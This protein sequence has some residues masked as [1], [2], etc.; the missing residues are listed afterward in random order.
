MSSAELKKVSA[1]NPLIEEASRELTD[2]LAGR[3][4]DTQIVASRDRA[5]RQFVATEVLAATAA[6]DAEIQQRARQLFVEYGYLDELIHD[7]RNAQASERVAAARILGEFGSDLATPALVE[8]LLDS[9]PEVR[10]AAAA[11]LMQIG[12]PPTAIGRTSHL[13]QPPRGSAPLLFPDQV[14]SDPPTSESLRH[15]A[16]EQSA[17]LYSASDQSDGADLQSLFLKENA[18]GKSVEEIENRLLKVTSALTEANKE[19]QLRAEAALKFKSEATTLR[20]R[21]EECRKQAEEATSLHETEIELKAQAEQARQT[22]RRSDIEKETLLLLEQQSGAAPE[23]SRLA[24]AERLRRQA[25]EHHRAEQDKSAYQ[26][27][28]TSCPSV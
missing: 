12:E 19:I 16:S 22:N 20:Q 8:A 7:L 4:S 9:E 2:L 18:L 11:A 13:Q 21:E 23:A 26:R 25:E 6:P 27:S 14:K 1:A 15:T 5:I 10:S 24:E 17:V 3:I 28:H